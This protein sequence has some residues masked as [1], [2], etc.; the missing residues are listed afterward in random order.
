MSADANEIDSE[1]NSLSIKLEAQIDS[2]TKE[3]S[4]L[5]KRIEKNGE[6][7]KVVRSRLN[8][9]SPSVKSTGYGSKSETVQE[10]IKRIIKPRFTQDDVEA[11][12]KRVNPNMVIKRDRIRA[13]LWSLQDKAIL[14][15]QVREGNNRQPAEFEKLSAEPNG[16]AEPSRHPR[17]PPPRTD[18]FGPPRP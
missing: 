15:K 5:E 12:I 1:L 14:I 11:E 4:V 10:A 18:A 3:I 6:L 7:L 16:D 8:A 2:D 13:V 17:I 9:G